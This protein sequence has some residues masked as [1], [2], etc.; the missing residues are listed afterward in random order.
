MTCAVC[1]NPNTEKE[2]C[3]IKPTRLLYEAAMKTPS[4]PLAN[5][6]A[7]EYTPLE[8]GNLSGACWLCGAET[9]QGVPRKKAIKPTFT[10]ADFA[11]SPQSDVVCEYCNWAL[12]WRT[13]R[14][15]SI[16]ATGQGL[17]HPSRQ[18]LREVLLSPPEPPF[19][20]CIATSGQKW[21]H[22]KGRITLN[23]EMSWVMF[24]ETP[25]LAPS[26]SV[27]QLLVPVEE[28]YTGG[29]SKTEILTGEYRPV[30]I[31]KFGVRKW[32]SLENQIAKHRGA[33]LF[34]V[35]VFVAQKGES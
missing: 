5:G 3:M 24:E 9:S 12:S 27:R 33:R 22:F 17:Q 4:A 7:A 2:D 13:L 32:E 10:D 29:F 14:N 8:P 19:L 6:K 26:E 31:N 23:K 34:E 1:G 11:Q 25:T 28:M 21:L 30:N 15:Y 35:V 16:L 20:L 18:E